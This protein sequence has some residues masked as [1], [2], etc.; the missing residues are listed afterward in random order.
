MEMMKKS[1]TVGAVMAILL[2]AAAYLWIG[3]STPPGQDPLSTLTPANLAD[4]EGA[5]GRSVEG[6]RLVLLL[7]PT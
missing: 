2:A 6:P 4:F 5:F 1:I 3:S 7:S